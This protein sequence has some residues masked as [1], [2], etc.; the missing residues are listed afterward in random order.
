MSAD[1]V[2]GLLDVIARLATL[3]DQWST[4]TQGQVKRLDEE[5]AEL[6]DGLVDQD[7]RLAATR[8]EVAALDD[9]LSVLRNDYRGEAA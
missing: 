7:H 1:V 5:L 4:L 3:L 8:Q 6:R 2:P 9:A